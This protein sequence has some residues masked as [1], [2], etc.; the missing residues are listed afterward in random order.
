MISA[1]NQE[2][3]AYRAGGKVTQLSWAISQV[4][5]PYR[6]MGTFRQMS[7]AIKQGSMA[8]WAIKKHCHASNG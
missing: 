1:I 7:W 8:H 6:E 2:S 3:M 4:S 5:K